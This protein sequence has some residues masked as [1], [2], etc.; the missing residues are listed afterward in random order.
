M[1]TLSFKF[2]TQWV[3]RASCNLNFKKITRWLHTGYKSDFLSG[4]GGEGGEEVR[5]GGGT[6]NN[7]ALTYVLDIKIHGFLINF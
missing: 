5:S 3:R 7:S 2:H 4:E 1:S 6:N